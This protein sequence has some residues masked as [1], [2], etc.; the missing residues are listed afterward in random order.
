MKISAW[1]IVLTC[2]PFAQAGIRPSFW[3]SRCAWEA[4][5]VVELA[6][7]PGEAR[8][9]VVAN[10]KGATQPGAVK[11]FP[12]LAATGQ[13]HSLL[14]DLAID[15]PDN[16][17]Y[18]VAPPM[19]DSDR[20]IVFLRPGDNPANWTMLT[21][22]I[23][24]QDG[25]AYAFEQTINPGPTHL[26]P[27]SVA[28]A[29]LGNGGVSQNEVQVRAEIDRL[30]QLR[31]IFDRALAIPKGATRAAELA[32]LMT[33]GDRVV[34]RGVLAELNGDGP[35]AAH[36]LRPYL[37]D[38][39]L[40][41]AHFL[42][43]DTMAVNRARDIRLDSII[44]RETG[45]WKATCNQTLDPNWIRNYGEP[46][47]YHYLRLVSALKIIQAL[48]INSDLPSV[49]E[50]GSVMNGCQHLIHQ[51]ELVELATALLNR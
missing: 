27:F 50:F 25:V 43:L 45:Y 32:Q 17:F 37:D 21:S 7:A 28:T 34:V 4:T 10:L 15:F 36:A 6:V 48:G 49:R 31:A 35:D 11:S 12:E 42:I 2:I 29:R 22:A 13:D 19:R 46:P 38:D 14:R 16:R 33:S 24:L 51:Q 1:Y 18:L 20:L 26:V 23:W 8:F 41:D 47:A 5:E 3:L 39:S 40:L 30:L 44:R 9:R